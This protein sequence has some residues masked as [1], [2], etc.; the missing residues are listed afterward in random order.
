MAAPDGNPLVLGANRA[1]ADRTLTTEQELDLKLAAETRGAM[2]NQLI[3]AGR[4]PMKMIR[5]GNSYQWIVNGR[6]DV[7]Y[8][9]VLGAYEIGDDAYRQNEITIFTL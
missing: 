7:G 8:R 3:I 9:S 2:Q 6:L 1:V 4:C 5:G